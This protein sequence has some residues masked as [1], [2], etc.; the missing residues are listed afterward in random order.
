MSSDVLMT[1]PNRD[2]LPTD[3]ITDTENRLDLVVQ[4]MDT[5]VHIGEGEWPIDIR[6]GIDWLGYFTDRDVN[7]NAL[8]AEVRR[9]FESLPNVVV[10]TTRG[11]QIFRQIVLYFEGFIN[12]RPFRLTVLGQQD[13]QEVVGDDGVFV[14]LV[15]KWGYSGI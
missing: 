13:R 10:S 15:L 3:L 5:V 1:G 2:L 14:P 8:A 6:E 9:E 11:E 4:Q 12:Q 7:V